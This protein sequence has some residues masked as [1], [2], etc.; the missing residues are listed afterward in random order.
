MSGV[1]TYRVEAR[2]YQKV[3][4][5]KSGKEV[6]DVVDLAFVMEFYG[7]RLRDDQIRWADSYLADTKRV[8]RYYT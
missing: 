2:Y 5:V 8:R 7:E 4:A 1:R 6:R 3:A